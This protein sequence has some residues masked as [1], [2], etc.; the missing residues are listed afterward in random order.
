[1]ANHRIRPQRISA[2]SAYALAGFVLAVII[3]ILAAAG[4]RH[5]ME[6]PVP[7]QSPTASQAAASPVAAPSNPYAILPPATVPSK[8]AECAQTITL[9]SNGTSGPLQ[10]AD[11]S[12]NVTEWNALSTVE[13][14]VM[15]LG[16][17]ASQAQVAAAM[18]TDVKNTRS[19]ATTNN[20]SLI[21]ANAYKLSKLYYGWHFSA[22]P[23]AILS[24]GTC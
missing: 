17:G 13:P 10:C 8:Q 22:S 15:T 16:Y 24:S 12:L 1:M 23:L 19:D 14:K 4:I 2:D 18:C 21:E 20:A 6:D 9:N 3:A 11:G 7:A 5:A